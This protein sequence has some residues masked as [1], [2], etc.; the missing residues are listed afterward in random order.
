M[1]KK[2][3]R[4]KPA[5][6]VWIHWDFTISTVHAVQN[7]KNNINCFGFT[8]T[9]SKV[10]FRSTEGQTFYWP[11]N[12]DSW[13]QHQNLMSKFNVSARTQA[14]QAKWAVFKI[15]GFVCKR[16]PSFP[17]HPLPVLLLA[18]FFAQ[19][20]TLI[21]HSLLKDKT[22]TLATQAMRISKEQEV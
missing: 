5:L 19:Q 8:H 22:E 3:K 12:Y 18:P 11:V 10:H 21:P 15:Q 16:F 6:I 9:S 13:W 20:L 4:A 17:P 1:D 2:N 7:T 14:W